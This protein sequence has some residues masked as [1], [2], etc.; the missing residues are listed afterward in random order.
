M[1]PS[2]VIGL[3]E[4]AALLL[5]LGVLLDL[6]LRSGLAG[7]LWTRGLIGLALGAICVAIM[8]NPWTFGSGIIFDTRS[9]ILSVGGLF[10]GALPAGIAAMIAVAF[11]IYM[12][13]SGV[14]MGVGTIVTSTL[15]GIA[16]RHYRR[17]ELSHIGTV[18]LLIFGLSVHS[19]LLMWTLALPRSL[20]LH[21]ISVI[22]PSFLILYPLATMILGKLLT[23]QLAHTEL[24]EALEKSE[25]NYRELVESVNSIILRVD[26]NGRITFSNKFAQAFFGFP[27]VRGSEETILRAIL[28]ESGK[29]RRDL[30]ES[31][32]RLFDSPNSFNAITI[33]TVRSD[34]QPAWISW[35]HRK[36]TD[37]EGKITEALF[38]GNNITEFKK[39]VDSLEQSEERYRTV[40]EFTYDWEYWVDPDGK[41][42]YVS[43]ACER[44]TGYSSAEFVS[45]FRLIEKI[46]DPEFRDTFL[47][48][49]D[50]VSKSSVDDQC[51]L[52]LRIITRNG[53]TKW[54]NHICRAVHSKDVRLLGHRGSNRDITDRKLAEEA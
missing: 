45:D 16:W 32:E 15:I 52:D 35:T 31:I 7:R 44:I 25:T 42:I 9:I 10:F 12:G 38:V 19:A 50:E 54:I 46:V 28:P 53:E 20:I 11:R 23:G 33:E 43:P 48:H 8:I 24:T 18:E 3:I 40:A 34:G 51:G 27:L 17:R 41:L 1:N 39:A 49:I 47:S 21:V 6:T 22:A 26:R 29:D 14:V 30:A 2:P 4:N 36:I 13:G 37:Q 5:A